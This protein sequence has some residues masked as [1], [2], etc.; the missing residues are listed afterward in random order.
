[1]RVLV[2][3]GEAARTGVCVGTGV[4]VA[5][6]TLVG[7]SVD[8]AVVGVGAKGRVQPA[9]IKA[10]MASRM[11]TVPRF[12]PLIPASFSGLRWVSSIGL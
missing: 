2:G 8:G 11:V 1:V 3:R 12:V 10:A 9:R 4:T 6:A 7:G 5:S